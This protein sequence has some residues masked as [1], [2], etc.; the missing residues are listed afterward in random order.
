MDATIKL[1]HSLYIFI[2]NTLFVIKLIYLEIEFWCGPHQ[3]TILSGYFYL[4]IHI[5]YLASVLLTFSIE[6][7]LLLR[8]SSI[9]TTT[10]I[11]GLLLYLVYLWPCPGTGLFMSYQYDLIFIFSL[12]FI[13][14]ITPIKQTYLFFVN[15]LDLP[16]FLDDN[17]WRERKIFK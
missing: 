12:N 10:V 1:L 3:K 2:E 11:L 17:G 7:Q 9:H 6:L 13:N 4:P 8:C 15:F 14:H 16:L 5:F